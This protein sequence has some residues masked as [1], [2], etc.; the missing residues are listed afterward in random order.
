MV[1][2]QLLQAVRVAASALL[3]TAVLTGASVLTPA[4]ADAASKQNQKLLTFTGTTVDGLAYKSTDVLKKPTVI[5]F[6]TPWCAI[7]RNESKAV[8][9]LST[10]YAGKVNFV[11]VGANGSVEEMKEFVGLQKTANITHLNDAKGKL[12]NRF[13]VVIQPTLVFVDKN[14]KIKTHVGPST[15]SYITKQVAALAK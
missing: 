4:P 13:G 1:K 10:K 6:W 14:G 9:A 3:I 7:C 12:W 2:A 5:W 8:A 11:G 15:T